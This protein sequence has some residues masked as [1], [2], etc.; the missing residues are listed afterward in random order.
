MRSLN[1]L[2]PFEFLF[3]SV[4]PVEDEKKPESF[5][6]NCSSSQPLKP[7]D[8]SPIKK[9]APP[10]PSR[11]LHW[12]MAMFYPLGRYFVLPIYFKRIEVIGRE[13]LP[14]SG[15]VILAP[16][17]RSRWDAM[18]LPYAAGH[19][20]TGRHL[21]FMVS[22]NEVTGLQGWFIRRMGG[23][24]VNTDRPAIASLRHGVE[25]LE[26]G[27]TLVIFPEGN[28]FRETCV[29]SL[30]PGLA[31]L[32][33]QAET[34]C[35]D[36]GIQVVPINIHYSDSLVPWRSSVRV[37]IGTPLRVP[38]Y[39]QGSHKQNARRL[40][41]DLQAAMDALALENLEHE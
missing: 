38:D 18:T 30:K 28:I 27:E 26:A 33:I 23:F 15:S 17:H 39:C 20:I 9:A 25:L 16:T 34:G 24:P 13:R 6:G 40:T 41:A 32:A 7:A 8:L 2:Y 4:F 35:T 22:A 14:S 31:R 5:E 12:L 3:K 10:A 11:V 29:Q 1:S 19:D 21:R 37:V 36:L